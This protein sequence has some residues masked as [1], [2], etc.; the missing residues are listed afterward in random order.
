MPAEV[1][2]INIEK[3]ITDRGSELLERIQLAE[4]KV[5]KLRALIDKAYELRETALNL[6]GDLIE[7]EN[8]VINL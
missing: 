3:R 8:E 1:D 6:K 4:N 5:A 7:W 2:F